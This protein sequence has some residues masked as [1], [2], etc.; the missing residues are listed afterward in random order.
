MEKQVAQNTECKVLSTESVFV[1]NRVAISIC[2]ARNQI[3]Q[4]K[5][6]LSSPFSGLVL[7]ASRAAL[8]L[9]GARRQYILCVDA[10]LKEA[11]V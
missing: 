7:A 3:G 1:K 9:G 8:A 5:S 2:R 11:I 4:C 10:F 6:H